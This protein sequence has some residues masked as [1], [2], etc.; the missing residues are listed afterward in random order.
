MASIEFE[1]GGVASI[2][3]NAPR[4]SLLRG[5][6]TK[7]LG[8]VGTLEVNQGSSLT[9]S[10]DSVHFSRTCERHHHFGRQLKEFVAAIEEDRDPWI[11]SDDGIRSL[12][13]VLAMYESSQTRE[14]VEL[15]A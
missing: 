8:T 6:R 9:F 3:H 12:A 4:Y 11:S 15:A 5:W 2:A 13:V 10:S 14:P 1:N 7:L